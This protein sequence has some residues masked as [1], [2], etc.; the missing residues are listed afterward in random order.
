MDHLR[1]GSPPRMSCLLRHEGDDGGRQVSRLLGDSSTMDRGTRRCL[2]QFVVMQFLRNHGQWTPKYIAAGEPEHLVKAAAIRAVLGLHNEPDA[3]ITTMLDSCCLQLAIAPGKGTLILG[4]DPVCLT[5]HDH[6]NNRIGPQQGHGV[7]GMPLDR[8]TVVL[9]SRGVLRSRDKV[10]LFK[11]SRQGL[12]DFNRTIL[13][14]SKR[15]AGPDRHVIRSLWKLIG[16]EAR[17]A[18]MAGMTSR[19][20]VR[21]PVGWPHA[22]AMPGPGGCVLARCRTARAGAPGTRTCSSR[23]VPTLAIAGEMPVR[24]FSSEDVVRVQR[25]FSAT[26][27]PVQPTVTSASR[28]V[29][30]GCAGLCV[31]G[32]WRPAMAVTTVTSTMHDG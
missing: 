25:S 22:P 15:I 8:Q 27:D 9:W 5:V 28:R 18:P 10:S 13:E 6:Y 7:V 12:K 11:L 1:T 14:Q 30:P 21:S 3:R 29:S 16:R 26:R 20:P 23:R 17:S 32:I 2:Q 31:V 4:D 19:Y 24:P